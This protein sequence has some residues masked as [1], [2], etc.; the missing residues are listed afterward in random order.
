MEKKTTN[1]KG[2]KV[3]KEKI[4]KEPKDAAIYIRVTSKEEEM[5]NKLMLRYGKDK[6]GIILYALDKLRKREQD[7]APTSEEAE[8]AQHVI[9]FLN[10]LATD[11]RIAAQE[12][13]G[14]K[15]LKAWA[16]RIKN[17]NESLPVGQQ[18]APAPSPI[19]PIY[20]P[21]DDFID[22]DEMLRELKF[23][24]SK[25]QALE[26][27]TYEQPFSDYKKTVLELLTRITQSHDA[28][29]ESIS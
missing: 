16:L 22:V 1:S 24:E 9:V 13:A 29:K 20:G 15:R 25:I 2:K 10:K 23:M 21:D 8:F 11:H 5:V 28:L 26:K 7:A 3:R 17:P 19:V 27:A 18:V 12:E 14:I 6:T 4:E